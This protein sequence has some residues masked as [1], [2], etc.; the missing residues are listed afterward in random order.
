MPATRLS[1]KWLHLCGR[2]AM[3]KGKRKSTQIDEPIEI[4]E[5]HCVWS[6]ADETT[7][8]AHI[9]GQRAK[10]GD[11]MN[12]DRTFWVAAAAELAAKGTGV[13]AAKSPDACHQK[14]GWADPQVKS[15]KNVGWE[16]YEALVEFLPSHIST[17]T[18]FHKSLDVNANTS[19]TTGSSS[20]SDIIMMSLE[21][22]LES[23]D[24]E[25]MPVSKDPQTQCSTVP[26]QVAPPIMALHFLL[27]SLGSTSTPASSTAVK[28]KTVDDNSSRQESHPPHSSKLGKSA[29]GSSKSQCIT[30]PLALEEFGGKVTSSINTATT[31]LQEAITGHFVE[32]VPMCKQRAIHQVQEEHDLDDHEVLKMIKVFQSD[33]M[34][35]DSYLNITRD[36]VC[37]LFLADYLQAHKKGS[38]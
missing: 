21:N 20:A 37:K 6:L 4:K 31:V 11:G 38:N 8:I 22:R 34:V 3:A 23:A 32:P 12:F 33:V 17:W 29:G 15:I 25:M 13:G 5:S 27:P 30:M 10:G 2:T 28:C 9:S 24:A 19:T 26:P 18:G 1:S 36:G 16:H 35:A 7:L 14:W